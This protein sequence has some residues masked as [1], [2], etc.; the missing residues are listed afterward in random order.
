MTLTQTKST[1]SRRDQRPH[2]LAFG[3]MNLSF[4]A[5]EDLKR[6]KILTATVQLIAKPSAMP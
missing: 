1:R 3:W 4:I 5:D 2:L 6:S